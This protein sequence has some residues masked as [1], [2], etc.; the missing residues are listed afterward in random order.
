MSF[1]MIPVLLI[2][3]GVIT[4]FE[5]KYKTKAII[6]ITLLTILSC[7]KGCDDIKRTQIR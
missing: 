3:I 6:S 1:I 2:I 4:S 5:F 7:F